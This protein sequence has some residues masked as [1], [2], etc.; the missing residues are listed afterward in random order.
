MEHVIILFEV[1]AFAA[2]VMFAV[3]L[4]CR[5]YESRPIHLLN[6][7]IWPL[8]AMGA[9]TAILFI[10]AEAGICYIPHIMWHMLLIMLLVIA[11]DK[12]PRIGFKYVQKRNFARFFLF[13]AV[14]SEVLAVATNVLQL[15][16]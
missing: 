15:V 16:M 12:F 1:L 5:R 14:F 4:D 11:L 3:I 8:S 13:L 7:G 2:L 9:V 6:F 10:N